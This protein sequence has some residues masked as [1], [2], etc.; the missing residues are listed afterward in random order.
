MCYSVTNL[1]HNKMT[2]EE[3]QNKLDEMPNLYFADAEMPETL[4]KFWTE[5]RMLN[6]NYITVDKDGNKIC[7]LNYCRSLSEL[8][9]ITKAKYKVSFEGFLKELIPVK[10]Y[11]KWKGFMACKSVYKVTVMF[12]P[13]CSGYNYPESE[14]YLL[15]KNNQIVVYK[16]DYHK[17]TESFDE[18]F[19]ELEKSIYYLLKETI[20]NYATK[21]NFKNQ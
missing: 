6:S 10:I 7:G 21:N 2:K 20:Q 18:K 15:D 8:Y 5:F 19:S 14:G 9:R 17:P 1:E 13:N 12:S 4:T 11:S 16:K 3:I